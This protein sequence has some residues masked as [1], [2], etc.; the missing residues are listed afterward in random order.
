MIVYLDTSAFVPLLVAEPGSALCRRLWD[1]A[2]EVVASRILCVEASAALAQA[3]RLGRLTEE[4]RRSAVRLLDQ[5]WN[6]LEIVEVDE[7]VVQ[8]ASLLA[9]ECTL[10]GYDAV[11][12]ASAERIDAPDLVV[13]SGDKKVIEACVA[14]G[15]ATADTSP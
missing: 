8:R 7:D 9:V 15:L 5:L 3:A 12:C 4:A 6:E 13:A 2:D 11:H 14:L 1:E 10:R